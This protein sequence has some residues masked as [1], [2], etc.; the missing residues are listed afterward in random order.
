MNRIHATT[1]AAFVILSTFLSV[2]A[3]AETLRIATWNL[4]WHVASDEVPAWIAQCDKSYVKNR[5]TKVWDLAAEGTPGAK[6]G[7]EITESRATLE[8]VDLSVMPPCSVYQ[9][10]NR[11]G[12]AITPGAYAKRGQ[13]LSQLLTREV[14]PDV[15]AFQEVSGTKA[16]VE[17]LGAA[18]S[19]YNVCSFDGKYKI[20]RLA[21]AWRKK[22]GDAAEACREVHEVSLPEVLPKDQVRP[23]YTVTLTLNG[24]NVRFLTVHLKSSCVSPLDRNPRR[25]DDE[26]V[27]ACAVLQQQVRPLEVAFEKL[28]QGVDH[29]VVLG[30]FNRNLAHELNQVS[31]AEPVRSDQA[32][33]L[34]TPLATGVRTR[35]LLLEIND[36]QPV[37]SKAALLMPQ[38]PGS[39]EL[40]AACEISKTNIPTA[41]QQKLLSGKAGLGCRNPI[42]L[43]HILVSQSLATAVSSTSKIGIGVFGGSLPPTANRPDPLLAVSDHCPLVA[44]IQL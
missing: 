12:I 17:A 32:T 15:I 19:D 11:K 28:G 2:P 20:Q 5:A 24:K 39:A 16:V 23:A 36:G 43:D 30:D 10:A 29:F 7:W 18:A 33:D 44:E 8:G 35:N 27:A 26:S 42:G 1:C 40:E 4:G 31:G 14:R 21:F 25:L 13:Q 37:S 34:T 6:R 3:S 38:C 22:F 41:E 9:T